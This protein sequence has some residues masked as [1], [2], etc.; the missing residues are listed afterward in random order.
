M[1]SVTRSNCQVC[2]NLD[3]YSKN[4]AIFV[5]QT[6]TEHALSTVWET[7]IFPIRFELQIFYPRIFLIWQ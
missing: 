7:L 4:T 5:H 1:I 2:S 3:H 6:L